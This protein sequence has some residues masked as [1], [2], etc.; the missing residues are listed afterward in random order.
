MTREELESLIAEVQ[1]R[2]RELNDVEVH[3]WGET[4]GYGH[5]VATRRIRARDTGNPWVQTLALVA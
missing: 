4:H 2:Q 3:P 1:H 5:A